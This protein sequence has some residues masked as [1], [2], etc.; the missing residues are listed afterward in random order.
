MGVY[1][2]GGSCLPLGACAVVVVG[3][4]GAPFFF[5]F[6]RRRK[7]KVSDRE[8]DPRWLYS[9]YKSDSIEHGEIA[10]HVMKC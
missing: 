4:G 7:T 1:A 9:A 6:S 2:G 3:G 8:F 10:V 5:F